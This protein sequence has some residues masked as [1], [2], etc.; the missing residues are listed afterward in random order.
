M[1]AVD[2]NFVVV[3]LSIL[4]ITLVATI[5][6]M[7][8]RWELLQDKKI[9]R[10]IEKIKKEKTDKQTAFKNEQAELDRLHETKAIDNDTYNRL[11][12]L[13]R[14]NEQK[15]EETMDTLLTAKDLMRKPKFKQKEAIPQ[16]KI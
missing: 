3:P 10:A 11:S 6:I 16:I 4:V 12:T 15:L 2:F 8:S 1:Q 14:M 9:K 5:L 7:E 13:L